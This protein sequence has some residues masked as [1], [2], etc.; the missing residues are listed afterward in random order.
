MWLHVSTLP[1]AG[2][3]FSIKVLIGPFFFKE[4]KDK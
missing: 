3:S 1:P 4:K 2:E